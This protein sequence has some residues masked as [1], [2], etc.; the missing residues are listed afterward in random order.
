MSTQSCNEASPALQWSFTGEP[1]AAARQAMLQW[2]F[3]GGCKW[4]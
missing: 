4:R 2:S 3:T 1:Q